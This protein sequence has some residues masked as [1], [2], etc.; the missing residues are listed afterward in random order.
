MSYNYWAI[1]ANV[2]T[3]IIHAK[4]SVVTR[5]INPDAGDGLK[6]PV[7]YLYQENVQILPQFNKKVQEIIIP[8]DNE[9]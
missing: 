4:F 2:A 7:D 1:F 5:M 6:P 8:I 9:R 3:Q